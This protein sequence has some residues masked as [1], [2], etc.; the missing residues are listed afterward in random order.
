M[1]GD[2]VACFR[3]RFPGRCCGGY[4]QEFDHKR[5]E[6]NDFGTSRDVAVDGEQVPTD[7]RYLSVKSQLNGQHRLGFML[8]PIYHTVH[9]LK[10]SA[11]DFV[12]GV[13]TEMAEKAHRADVIEPTALTN[14]VMLRANSLTPALQQHRDDAAV[15]A[16]RRRINESRAGGRPPSS[17]TKE[18]QE[19][20][21]QV[22]FQI[23]SLSNA[24][25]A[26]R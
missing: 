21:E 19:D 24:N 22:S 20:L 4:D 10:S 2:S 8:L 12:F 1:L 15:T 6:L 11:S 25:R 9:D 7:R 26:G 13:M 5:E 16:E 17:K 3:W 18:H 23:H 14:Q